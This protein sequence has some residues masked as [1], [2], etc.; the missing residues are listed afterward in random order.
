MYS[1]GP[2]LLQRQLLTLCGFDVDHELRFDMTRERFNREKCQG[3]ELLHYKSFFPVGWM[4]AVV[5]TYNCISTYLIKQ[6]FRRAI[7]G[8]QRRQK[9]NG[10]C[11]WEIVQD[12]IFISIIFLQI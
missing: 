4:S 1:G 10:T 5:I 3:I 6:I 12:F 9:M 7:S 8:I 2:D 11:S